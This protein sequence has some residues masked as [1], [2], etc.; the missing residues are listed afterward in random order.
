MLRRVRRARGSPSTARAARR[1]TRTTSP[2]ATAC[3]SSSPSAR[4][5]SATIASLSAVVG[6]EGP[7]WSVD[8]ALLGAR[9]RRRS[10]SGCGGSTSS[11]R[12]G[13]S[14]TRAASAR[15]AGATGTSR[16]SARW[17]ATGAGL[18]VGGLLPRGA[19]GARRD[20]DRALRGRSR[21]AVYVAGIFALYAYLTRSFDPLPP[22]GC[23][24]APPWCSSR[25][26]CWPPPGAS[27]AW[28]LLVLA[29]TP[30]VTVVGYELAGHRHNEEVL[31]RLARDREPA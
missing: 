30:W 2:S 9:R 4:A 7:G 26:C 31:A 19:L 21:S 13:R 1:G 5:S 11:S 27:M 17:S 15:S 3:W 28:C 14:C 6:P 20:R 16:S 18:H 10:R 24:P 12:A 29:L 23:W 8:A 22:A 25:R